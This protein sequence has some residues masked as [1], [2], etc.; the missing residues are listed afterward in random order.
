MSGM[1]TALTVGAVTQVNIQLRVSNIGD[2]AFQATLA[3][4]YRTNQ[5]QVQRVFNNT[6]TVRTARAR[7]MVQLG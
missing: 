6:M 1:L 2:D 7:L 5:L 4:R 3:M